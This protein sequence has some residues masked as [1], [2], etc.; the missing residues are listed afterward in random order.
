MVNLFKSKIIRCTNLL[1]IA[2]VILSC[3]SMKNPHYIKF[4]ETQLNQKRKPIK[5]LIIVGIGKLPTRFFL[6]KITNR[7][8][9]D[10]EKKGIKTTYYF[11]GDDFAK[12]K[13]Q[14]DTL[15]I[16]KDCD[17]V[18]SFFQTDSAEV[19]QVVDNLY[20]PAPTTFLVH[21]Q[22]KHLR[23]NQ[24]FNIKIYEPKNLMQ[25]FWQ[26]ALNIDYDFNDPILYHTISNRIIK[27]LKKNNLCN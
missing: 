6:D 23:F 19:R 17:A 8:I 27:S 20:M 16:V 18:M 14:F 7:L 26:S 10:L 13:K 2:L 12:A 25:S 21:A 5:N 3:A 22:I 1:P 24:G 15:T 11:L 4:D 9:T